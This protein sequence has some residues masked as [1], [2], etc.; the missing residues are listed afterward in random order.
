MLHQR[1]GLRFTRGDKTKPLVERSCAALQEHP[2]ANRKVS[3]R[4]LRDDSCDELR[5]MP[6]ALVVRCNQN[7][8]QEDVVRVR[9]V[10]NG[11]DH[12]GAHHHLLI[13]KPGPLLFE[14][15]SLEVF[16]PATELPFYD[17]AIATPVSW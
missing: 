16:V 9:L 14:E 1:V 12:L 7:L 6:R 13:A 5:T 3:L 15:L 17:L 8:G 10:G 4:R 11:S 2:E